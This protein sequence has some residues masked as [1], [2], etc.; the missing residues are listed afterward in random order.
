MLTPD[1]RPINGVA[2]TLAGD[3]IVSTQE[4]AL[5]KLTGTSPA[6]YKFVDFFPASNAVG[7]EA[8]VSMGNDIVYMR[9]GGS[10][11]TL[12]ATQNYGD[13]A[14][15]DLSRWISKTVAGLTESITVYDQ[16]T[17][18]VL[19]FVSGKVLVLFKDILY[20]GALVGEKGERARVSPW[21]VYRTLDS[22]TF[23]TAAAKYMRRPGSSLYSVYFGSSDGRIFDLNGSGLAGDAGSSAIQL[24]RKSRLITEAD[25]INL[26]RHVPRGRVQYQRLNQVA[27]NIEMDWADEYVASTASLILKGSPAGNTGAFYGGAYY[28]GG[29][30]YYSQGFSFL[31]KISHQNFSFVG[32]GP[33]C[34]VT[35]SSLTPLQYQVDNVELL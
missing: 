26:M 10:I 12:V 3:L 13:V 31:N 15:D 21:S 22:G 19:F 24:I 18:R 34:Y 16:N 25:G 32:R 6:T 28:Y 30:T 11:D 9:Q 7:T 35:C 27:F 14:A 33:G 8:M 29:T 23:N 4:G 2:Q 1:L 20:G 5:F 17:Q